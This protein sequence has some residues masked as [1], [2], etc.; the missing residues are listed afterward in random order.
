MNH[1]H[2]FTR[3]YNCLRQVGSEPCLHTSCNIA[4]SA[5]DAIRAGH[6][7]MDGLLTASAALHQ[8]TAIVRPFLGNLDRSTHDIKQDM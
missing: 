5:G 3:L 4:S 7:T 1:V 8:H 2:L 6:Q